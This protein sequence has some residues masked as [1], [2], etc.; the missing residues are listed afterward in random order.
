MG[1]IL[2]L[3][4]L[5]GNVLFQRIA[6]FPARLSYAGR[7]QARASGSNSKSRP[8]LSD[9]HAALT[10]SNTVYGVSREW[11]PPKPAESWYREIDG[12]MGAALSAA[13][14]MNAYTISNRGTWLSFAYK[15]DLTALVESDPNS[16]IAMLI[17]RDHGRVLLEPCSIFHCDR[18]FES[19]LRR[20]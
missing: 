6:S 18:R 19:G 14:A 11:I 12:G 8:R 7:R 17:L 20:R 4:E 13:Q 2:P 16:S 9:C 3:V 1:Q 15:G 10:R 5:G